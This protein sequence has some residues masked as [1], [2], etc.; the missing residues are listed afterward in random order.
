[1]AVKIR[2]TEKAGLGNIDLIVWQQAI[3]IKGP[4]SAALKK[5]IYQLHKYVSLALVMIWS[6]QL[7]S[8]VI[9]VFAPETIPAADIASGTLTTGA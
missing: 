3:W 4:M 8:G 7:L 6:V 1:M 2:P 5:T 9:L